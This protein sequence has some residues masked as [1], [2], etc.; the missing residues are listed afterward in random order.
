LAEVG[1]T[2]GALLLDS[3]G[4]SALSEG[5]VV[6]RAAFVRARREGRHVAIP[7][8]VLAEIASGRPEDARI[9]R[10]IKG[11]DF[12]VLLTPA[13]AREA[14]V[15]REPLRPFDIAVRRSKSL[16]LP[17]LTRASWPR[18]LPSVPRSSSRP[19]PTIWRSFAT[20]QG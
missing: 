12:E 17:R 1:L 7:A 18:R 10:V 20:R 4:I 2:P 9:N 19:I 15:I 5:N 8:A 13:R 11:V 3:G 6:A 14:G 16:H